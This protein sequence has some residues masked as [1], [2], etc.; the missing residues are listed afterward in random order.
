MVAALRS[1]LLASTPGILGWNYREDAPSSSSAS[2]C[3]EPSPV[4]DHD[5]DEPEDESAPEDETPSKEWEDW[6][7]WDRMQVLEKRMRVEK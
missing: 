6:L 7:D 4:V 3:G 2:S 5:Y 1:S